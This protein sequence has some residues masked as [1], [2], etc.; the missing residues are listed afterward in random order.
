MIKIILATSSPHRIEAFKFLGI[1]FEA[2]GSK[3]DE[4]KLERNNPKILVG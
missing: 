2:E 3:V 1:D 4:F